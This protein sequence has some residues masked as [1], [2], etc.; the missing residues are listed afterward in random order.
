MGIAWRMTRR[1]ATGMEQPLPVFHRH[2]IRR[3][4]RKIVLIQREQKVRE[5]VRGMCFFLVAQRGHHVRH[6]GAGFRSVRIED[7]RLDILWVHPGTDRGQTR[8]SLGSTRKRSVA[9]VTSRAIELLD[10]DQ[11]L[12][13]RIELARD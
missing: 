3:L 12:E 11:A 5:R 7:E 1:T 10:Q 6:G 8:R 9:R 2:R 13:S 4:Q